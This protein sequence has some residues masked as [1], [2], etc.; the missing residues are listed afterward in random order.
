MSVLACFC[1][2]S[3]GHGFQFV[4][5]RKLQNSADCRRFP[6]LSKFCGIAI[7]KTDTVFKKG[8]FGCFPSKI[9]REQLSSNC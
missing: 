8:R 6:F 7:D 5:C 2:Y 3:M 4:E 1:R 9:V